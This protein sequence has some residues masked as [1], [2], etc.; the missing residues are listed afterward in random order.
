MKWWHVVSGSSMFVF[1]VGS[2]IST[3]LNDTVQIL[4]LLCLRMDLW[5]LWSLFA[6]LMK[7]H[8]LCHYMTWIDSKERKLE[9]YEK[10]VGV[11]GFF[12]EFV[13]WEIWDWSRFG[14][15]GLIKS[16]PAQ[17]NELWLE[18]GEQ[19]GDQGFNWLTPERC[20]IFSRVPPC[21]ASPHKKQWPCGH[22]ARLCD[23][24]CFAHLGRERFDTRPSMT[25]AL[26]DLSYVAFNYMAWY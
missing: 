5:K 22:F 13:P 1:E 26:I 7:N 19:A 18:Y 16:Y 11:H 14:A 17:L 12:A 2:F 24:L 15:W 4:S 20:A 9:K 21:I 6:G 3:I 23:A 10:V 8:S 25:S